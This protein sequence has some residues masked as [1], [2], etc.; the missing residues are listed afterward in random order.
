MASMFSSDVFIPLDRLDLVDELVER[1]LTAPVVIFK[2]S[3]TCGISAFA[4]D[5]LLAYR[6]EPGSL[7][8]HLV[9]VLGGREI[10]R[11]IASRCGVRHESPQVLLLVD[12]AVAWSASHYGITGEAVRRAVS[13]AGGRILNNLVD[14]PSP[15]AYRRGDGWS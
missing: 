6:E 4:F 10:S 11:A 5:E 3:P 7:D 8:I 14:E 15:Q 12:G 2:H 1:S 9:D 13:G